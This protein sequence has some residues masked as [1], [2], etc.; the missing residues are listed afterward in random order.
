MADSYNYHEPA[1]IENRRR[2]ER[3]RQIPG[4][5]IH[6]GNLPLTIRGSHSPITPIDA[7]SHE[8]GHFRLGHKESPDQHRA[9]RVISD[10][11]AAWMDAKRL[12]R[13]LD[14]RAAA[15]AVGTYIKYHKG[16]L[17]PGEFSDIVRKRQ[18]LVEMENPI[19]SSTKDRNIIRRALIK[20][21][22]AINDYDAAAEALRSPGSVSVVKHINAEEKE[23]VEELTKVLKQIKGNPMNYFGQWSTY[24]GFSIF[25]PDKFG[26]YQIYRPG[27][28]WGKPDMLYRSLFEAKKSIYHEVQA[29]TRRKS[30]PQYQ[31]HTNYKGFEIQRVTGD[32]QG[33]RYPGSYGMNMV[34]YRILDPSG[35][36]LEGLFESAVKAKMQID[37]LTRSI[38]DSVWEKVSGSGVRKKKK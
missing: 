12:N 21:Y 22:D 15:S 5:V 18:A 6:A 23:H 30:N 37:W 29:M 9:H 14:T 35:R 17:S 2:G 24:M 25:G 8:L 11:I 4:G 33:M 13:S 26:T 31:H 10:E 38:P 19:K 1:W 36:S 27:N 7:L 3:F 32:W 34:T 28:T 16:D 20:E